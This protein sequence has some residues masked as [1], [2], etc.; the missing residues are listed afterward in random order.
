MTSMNVRRPLTESEKKIVLAQDVWGL[1]NRLND[2]IWL[3]E[4]HGVK[5]RLQC[6]RKVVRVTRLGET[7]PIEMALP[8][9]SV[10]ADELA[11]VLVAG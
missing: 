10:D 5:V 1:V 8:V 3:A 2:A 9:V 4:Y 7:E 11:P 6:T